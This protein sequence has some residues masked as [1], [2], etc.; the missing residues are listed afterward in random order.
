MGAEQSQMPGYSTVDL[1]MSEDERKQA[2]YA[3]IQKAEALMQGKPADILAG[4]KTAG[5]GP[6]NDVGNQLQ[7]P[8]YTGQK[9]AWKLPLSSWASGSGKKVSGGLSGTGGDQTPPLFDVSFSTGPQDQAALQDAIKAALSQGIEGSTDEEGEVSAT[10]SSDGGCSDKENPGAA[11][12]PEVKAKTALALQRAVMSRDGAML[13]HLLRF[14]NASLEDQ[15]Q[16]VL[17][18]LHVAAAQGYGEMVSILALL[19]ANLDARSRDMGD[20]PLHLAAAAGSLNDRG[21]QEVLDMLLGL[22]ASADLPN[23]ASE[24]RSPLHVAAMTGSVSALEKL[25][26]AGAPRG[27][28]DK[29][30]L[31]PVDLAMAC[32]AKEAIDYLNALDA[33]AQASKI[34]QYQQWLS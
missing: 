4:T 10:A 23:K 14:E 34:K 3:L 24:G 7:P 11:A 29:D 28:L 25:L 27:A 17:A 8:S 32:G 13:R 30:N 31:R 33:K 6:L 26:A 22:G 20:T 15:T 18:P 1:D 21:R 5:K 2:L 16:E 19:G 12:T 9:A